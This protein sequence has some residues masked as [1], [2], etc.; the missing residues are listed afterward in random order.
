MVQWRRLESAWS[1]LGLLAQFMA[2]RR[3]QPPRRVHRQIDMAQTVK[4][5]K[6]SGTSS[7]TTSFQHK[8]LLEFGLEITQSEHNSVVTC[9]VCLFC[10][11]LGRSG[12]TEDNGCECNRTSNT[13]Y[14]NPPFR[15]ENFA[16][17]L[18]LQHPDDFAE[19]KAHSNQE[20]KKFFDARKRVQES[21]HRY[22]NSMQTVLT[23]PI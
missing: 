9:V 23:I 21:M 12:A 1:G 4:K 15:K 17:H 10:K 19:Y 6:T 2:S 13:K 22:L 14:S 8:H 3:L 16:S 11:R 7:R 18:T 20:K 5:R